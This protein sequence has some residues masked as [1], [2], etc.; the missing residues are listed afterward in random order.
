MSGS[1]ALE[2]LVDSVEAESMSIKAKGGPGAVSDST[3]EVMSKCYY[4]DGTNRREASYEEIAQLIASEPRKRHLVWREQDQ[5]WASWRALPELVERVKRLMLPELYRGAPSS[6]SAQ[7][8][9]GGGAAKES[10]SADF[11]VSDQASGAGGSKAGEPAPQRNLIASRDPFAKIITSVYTPP[12]DYISVPETDFTRFSLELTNARY[13]DIYVG[14]EG[15]I[16]SGGVFVKTTRLFRINDDV[17]VKVNICGKTLLSFEAQV[18][19]MR[20]P[21]S[22][23]EPGIGIAWPALTPQQVKIIQRVT[24]GMDY[25]FYDA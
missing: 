7:S 10:E 25:L 23:Q 1:S 13:L 22:G 3:S 21:E 14:L 20:V 15:T 9:A 8:A 17:Q 2:E 4:S 18:A 11:S 5:R 6:Q 16:E 24:R 19:W 12:V